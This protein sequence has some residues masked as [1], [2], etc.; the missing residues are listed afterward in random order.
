[1][2]ATYGLLL[3]EE[4]GSVPV[5]DGKPES[6]SHFVTEVKWTLSSTKKDEKALLAAKIIKKALQSGQPTLVQLMYKLDPADFKTEYSVEKLVKYL[7]ESPLNR[8]PLPDA[9]NKIGGYYRRLNRRP[10]EALPAFLIREDKT[11]DDMLRALQRLLRERELSFEDYDTTQEELKKFCGMKDGES[12]YYG[13]PEGTDAEGE[14]P[15]EEAGEDEEDEEEYGRGS[16]HGSWT[17]RTSR[18]SRTSKTTGGKGGMKG[19]PKGK[20]LLERLMEKGLMPL[21]ALDVIR[22]WM[23]LEMSTSTEEERRIV[24]AATR[25]RLGYQ[26]VKQALLA[27]YEDRGKGGGRPFAAGKSAMWN[28]IEYDGAMDSHGQ[29][30]DLPAHT[31]FTDETYGNPW[32]DGGQDWAYYGDEQAWEEEEMEWPTEAPEE[33][34]DEVYAQLREEQQDIE[35]QR[36]DLE[37]MMAENDRNLAEARKAV[38]SA[39]RDRGWHGSVQQRQSRPTSTYMTKGGKGKFSGGKGKAGK[40][41]KMAEEAHWV[42][43]KKGFK[44]PPF[45]GKAK[46]QGKGSLPWG[47][48]FYAMGPELDDAE[49]FTTTSSTEPLGDHKASDGNQL[50]AEEGLV[51]TGATATAGGQ[52]AVERLCAAVAAARPDMKMT[53]HE[54]ARPYFRYG[55]GKWGR[56][57]YK[58]TMSSKNISVNVFALPSE[59]VPVLVGMRELKAMKAVLGCDGGKCILR[60]NMVQLRET[61]KGHLVVDFVKQIFVDTPDC[62]KTSFFQP[63]RRQAPRAKQQSHYQWVPKG[64][65]IVPR[66]VTFSEAASSYHHYVLEFQDESDDPEGRSEP[67]CFSVEPEEGDLGTSAEFLGVS[68][69]QAEHL[70]LGSKEM[71]R[72]RRRAEDSRSPFRHREHGIRLERRAGGDPEGRARR[73]GEGRPRDDPRHPRR[74]DQQPRYGQ[75]WPQEEGRGHDVR[76]HQEDGW[77]RER[78]SQGARSVAVLRPPRTH[79]WGKSL[80]PVERV[81]EV[82]LPDGVHTSSWSTRRVDPHESAHERD[83][84]SRTP[85]PIRPERFRDRGQAGQEHDRHR[86]Q[87]EAAHRGTEGRHWGRAEGEGQ[88]S[89]GG[90]KEE[91]RPGGLGR[92]HPGGRRAERAESSPEERSL[93]G[94]KHEAPEGAI[95]PKGAKEEQ[96]EEV[97]QTDYMKTEPIPPMEGSPAG[98]GE[99]TESDAGEPSGEASATTDDPELEWMEKAS[100][101]TY[102]LRNQLMKACEEFNVSSILAALQPLDVWEVACRTGTSFG[103]AGGLRGATVHCKTLDRGYDVNKEADIKT[104]RKECL[105]SPPWRLWLSPACVLPK[106]ENDRNVPNYEA[107]LRKKRLKVR[108]QMENI[109]TLVDA[110]TDRDAKHQ[111]IYL[112]MPTEARGT[113]KLEALKLIKGRMERHGKKVYYTNVSACELGVKDQEGKLVQKQWTVMHNDHEFHDHMHKPCRHG[114]EHGDREA[115]QRLS[116]AGVP[117]YPPQMIFIIKKLWQGQAARRARDDEAKEVMMAAHALD[118]EIALIDARAEEQELLAAD[119]GE[120]R[121]EEQVTQAMKDQALVLLHRLHKA[122]GHPSNRALARICRDR[123]MPK[124]L[125][126]LALNLECQACLSTKRGEQLLVPHSVGTKPQPWQMVGVDVFE[127]VFPE[128]RRKARYLIMM[129]LVMRYMCVELLWEGPMNET[130]TD[131]GEKLVTVFSETWLQHRPRPEWLLCDPQSSLSKGVFSEFCHWIGVGLAVTPGEGHW[132]NG[133]VETAVKTVKKTMR[134]LR[135]DNKDLNPRTCGHLAVMAHNNMNKV[136]GFSPIQ[137]AF[138]SDPGQWNRETDPLEVNKMA[139]S[140]PTEFWNLQRNRETAEATYKQELARE[141]F[142]RLHNA[143]PRPVLD[144]QVGDWVCVW[145]NSTLKA[146]RSKDSTQVNPEPRFIGPGRVAMV[147]PSVLPEG[148]TNIIWVLM[149]TNLWRCA[150]EQLRFASEQEVVTELL[151]YGSVITRPVQQVLSGLKRVIDVSDEPAP[152]R[153]HGLEQ[154]LPPEPWR[155]GAPEVQQDLTR[156]QSATSWET[157]LEQAADQWSERLARHARPPRSR[158]PPRSR[159]PI[160]N[161]SVQE[162]IQRWRTLETVNLNRRK[163]GL[164][165]LTRMPKTLQELSIPDAWELDVE[166]RRLI[167]HHL[168]W[169]KEMFVPTSVASCPVDKE[170]F[171]GKRTTIWETPKG[172]KGSLIDSWLSNRQPDR[173]LNDF[174]WRGSTTFELKEGADPLKTKRKDPPES[175]RTEKKKKKLPEPGDKAKQEPVKEERPAV[176]EDQE[177]MDQSNAAEEPASSSKPGPQIFHMAAQDPELDV[178]EETYNMIKHRIRVLEQEEITQASLKE[179]HREFL[180]LKNEEQSLLKKIKKACD[181]HEKAMVIELEVDDL[182]AFAAS[183][184][185]Y[186]KSKLVGPASAKEVTYRNLDKKDRRRM[187]EAMAREISEVLRSQVVKAA[188]EGLSEEEVKDRIIPMRWILTW[189]PV[190][191][192]KPPEN[193]EHSVSTEDGKHKAKARIVLIGYKHPDLARRNPR[194]GQP[195]LMTASP[196]LSRLGRNLLLQAAAFDE[197]ILECADAKSAFLQ[198]DGGIGTSPLYTR[199]VPELA[200]ALGLAPGSLMEV[201]GAI[202]GLTNAPRIFWLDVDQKLRALG[203]TPHEVDKCIW[204]FKDEQGVVYGRV[205]V[206]V[207]DFLIAGNRKDPRWIAM[208]ER[209]KKLYEWSPWKEGKFT[210]AGLEIQQL[211]NYQIV[212]TQETYC[213]SL[214]PIVIENDKHRSDSS[215][216]TAAELSQYRGLVMKA[217][218]RAVQ[219]AFQ[220]NARV[221]I[222]ASGVSKATVAS[223]R[224]AN[225]LMKELRKTAKENLVFHNHNYGKDQKLRWDELVAVHFGDA[226]H[227]NRIDGSSTGGYITGFAPPQILEGKESNLTVIDWRSWKL[228]RPTKG[229]NSSECQAMYEAEDRGWKCRLFWSLLN[230]E[231]LERRNAARLASRMESLLV[232]DSRG[233]YDAVTT[234]DSPLL[235]MTNARTGVEAMSIQKGIRDDGRCYFTWVPSDLNLA[236]CLTK[237]TAEAFKVASLYHERKA[238]VVRF[239]EEFVSARKQQRLRKKKQDLEAKLMTARVWPADD[240]EDDV[241]GMS[242]DID[243]DCCS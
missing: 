178:S 182:A 49:F 239:N 52:T 38:A 199:G 12:I 169:R 209:L 59:G 69:E 77:R 243:R 132:Q 37:A 181:N 40:S 10:Q 175:T 68:E 116:E 162:Q 109:G 110:A 202:Y 35:Q 167:R 105:A 84:G 192:G 173:I 86:G 36:R 126:D 75:R 5:W 139:G 123:G 171:T 221:G 164:P 143:A 184:A 1:M 87:G 211:Q 232:T 74:G 15:A 176:D 163:D 45:K 26:E 144:Y 98:A 56:A 27:M 19:E 83:R 124:W 131:S 97:N 231:R 165:P 3:K 106:E 188:S 197:H 4:R 25:N 61:P 150:P 31:Y 157:G 128:Q 161:P 91:E 223:L 60:G 168:T 44:G 129:C 190:P 90:T 135:N 222:A 166:N 99:G 230:G 34:N 216:L 76:R 16:W 220:Y 179:V 82:W 154:G 213:N 227:N 17:S 189:K 88:D 137:W 95:A 30:P 180:T 22:G 66:S 13:P 151:T 214:R 186:T 24:K 187:D 33:P 212:V 147:E 185:T 7:E 80:R 111:R 14:E 64:H 62:I 158:T 54:S 39:A 225:S 93:Q 101:I 48:S 236:D 96:A 217:Q 228:E 133:A 238:W 218:W 118:E 42:G 119:E 112:E 122:A 73:G 114:H 100:N 23:I 242:C 140:K 152:D 136:K 141:T 92:L 51:D 71:D 79:A 104:M 41:A 145:R 215:E 29:G 65:S 138:G 113:W 203:A 72:D 43:A 224:E 50:K 94:V 89:T 200:A 81:R 205:G 85:P 102:D 155:E 240:F 153:E 2:A 47:Q 156:A 127:L 130:G 63:I 57:L 146:R 103:G 58:V 159:S 142:T 28:E 219:T 148:R 191:D 195:E 115:Y 208:R 78:P 172:Q 204:I 237:A 20:D 198:A 177:E 32:W 9:G 8:Q 206:H 121:E 67:H 53:I 241:K 235:G 210:F 229:T 170:D 196:T 55:S 120:V 46:G 233:V 193:E 160:T 125:V 201:V 149:G 11:H 18:T 117:F 108:K 194:T 6:F 183:G 107:N 226:G 207:D 70:L 234:S 174:E 134:R 21:S